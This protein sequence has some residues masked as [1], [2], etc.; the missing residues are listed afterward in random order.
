MPSLPASSVVPFGADQTLF[1]VV[2]R[3]GR[4][5]GGLC[6][7]EIEQT[8]RE[9]CGQFRQADDRE[10]LIVVSRILRKRGKA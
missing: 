8:D 4:K 5:G 2:D 10:A 7:A 9:S 6:E 3:T 1:V